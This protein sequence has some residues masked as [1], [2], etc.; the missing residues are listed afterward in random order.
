MHAYIRFLKLPSECTLRDYTHFFTSKAGFQVE[1][2]EILVAE[3]KLFK[4]PDWKKQIVLVLDEMKIKESPVYD[5]HE[6]KV[7]SFVNL[8]SVNDQLVRFE[9]NS[10][11]N[12]H[13]LPVTTHMLVLMVRGIF[14]HLHFPYAHFPAANLS[15]ISLFWLFGR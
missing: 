6:A 13:P 11:G 9:Q 7:V 5:K 12:K 10:S 15:A 2:D 3:T 14:T 8:G 4:L 1:V